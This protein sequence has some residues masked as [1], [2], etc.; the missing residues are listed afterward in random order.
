MVL[1]WGGGDEA[2]FTVF[3]APQ[4]IEASGAC[5]AYRL[6]GLGH[7]HNRTLADCGADWATSVPAEAGQFLAERVREI[8]RREY[9]FQGDGTRFG[10]HR[11]L[12]PRQLIALLVVVGILFYSLLRYLS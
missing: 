10:P 6:L 4:V 1:I 3:E 12:E 2:E 8:R 11:R 5:R 7:S 9:P